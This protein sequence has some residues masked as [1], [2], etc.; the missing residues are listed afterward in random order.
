MKLTDIYINIYTKKYKLPNAIIFK[1]LKF[2]S[3]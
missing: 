2:E 3:N 1:L